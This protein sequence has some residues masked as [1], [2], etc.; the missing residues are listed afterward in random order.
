AAAGDGSNAPVHESKRIPPVVQ[1]NKR[2][3][4][5]STGAPIALTAKGSLY[6]AN[7]DTGAS[8]EDDEEGESQGGGGNA[9]YG[10]RPRTGAPLPP[11]LRT[12][13]T[14]MTNS[15]NNNNH[16][17]HNSMDAGAPPSMSPPQRHQQQRHQQQ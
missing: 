2:A 3:T 6:K 12:P 1:T 17:S 4:R 9:R 15:N 7:K 5:A 10:R 8:S 13:A 14:A 11:S 16:R